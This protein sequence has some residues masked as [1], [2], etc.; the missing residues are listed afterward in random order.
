MELEKN[1]KFT[2]KNILMSKFRQ[3]KKELLK[4][5]KIFLFYNKSNM[6]LISFIALLLIVDGDIKILYNSYYLA[7]KKKLKGFS[8]NVKDFRFMQKIVLLFLGVSRQL[9]LNYCQNRDNLF[10]TIP[11]KYDFTDLFELYTISHVQSDG[12]EDLFF[13]FKFDLFFINDYFLECFF[14]VL[15]FT[16]ILKTF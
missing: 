15:R 1:Y 3:N 6:C 2:I 5:L 13:F 7:E 11:L 8:I 12:I 9:I 4:K 16:I 10:I 14:R